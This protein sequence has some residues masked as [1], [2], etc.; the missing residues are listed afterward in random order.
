VIRF[1]HDRRQLQG[2]RSIEE[3][4][5]RLPQMDGYV[6]TRDRDAGHV[7]IMLGIGL[8]DIQDGHCIAPELFIERIGRVLRMIGRG[9]GAEFTR[10]P[11]PGDGSDQGLYGDDL[12][13]MLLGLRTVAEQAAARKGPVYLINFSRKLLAAR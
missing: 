11:I 10:S 12:K 4:A 1:F 13:F 8:D 9:Q 3:L 6:Q 2:V 7:F 5:R